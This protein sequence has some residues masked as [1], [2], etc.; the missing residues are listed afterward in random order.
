MQ[1]LYVALYR[2]PIVKSASDQFGFIANLETVCSE[3]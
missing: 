1:K 2:K 3:L